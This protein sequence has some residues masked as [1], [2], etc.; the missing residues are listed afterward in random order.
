MYIY[1][2]N[3]YFSLFCSGLLHCTSD[4]H[5]VLACPLWGMLASHPG[6]IHNSIILY[7]QKIH[8]LYKRFSAQPHDLNKRNLCVRVSCFWLLNDLLWTLFLTGSKETLSTVQHYHLTRGPETSVF[9][10]SYSCPV[11]CLFAL[12][13]NG[14]LLPRRTFLGPCK[15]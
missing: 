5:P 12:Y 13:S 7:L 2:V 15:S 10:K 3:I 1:C 11:I 4:L 9:M 6:E 14:S 8:I